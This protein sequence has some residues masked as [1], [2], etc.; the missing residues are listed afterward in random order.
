MKEL[1]VLK[2]L[3]GEFY[4]KIKRVEKNLFT[5]D[6][7]FIPVHE[8]INVVI[9]MRRVGKTYILYQH[10]LSLLKTGIERST[11]LYINFEDDRLLP[12][13]QEKL[14]KL[15]D[16]FYALYPENHEKKCYL[17]FDEIQNINGWSLVVR[18]LHDT[19]NI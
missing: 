18:R 17:F 15:V 9:G 12:L 10:I 13:T 1:V 5:R 3:L 7:A 8:K 11:L 14:A 2:I 16:A 4:D 19:K 6:V